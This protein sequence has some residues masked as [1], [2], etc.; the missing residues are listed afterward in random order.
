[1]KPPYTAWARHLR[2]WQACQRRSFR[3]LG[4]VA[5][6]IYDCLREEVRVLRLLSA[7][8]LLIFN[9]ISERLKMPHFSCAWAFGGQ[10]L[11]SVGEREACSQFRRKKRR[12]ERRRDGKSQRMIRGKLEEEGRKDKEWQRKEIPLRHCFEHPLKQGVLL[13][14]RHCRSEYHRPRRARYSSQHHKD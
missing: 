14:M 5:P 1:M 9:V 12:K 6:W 4:S 10:C 11:S 13:G 2:A 3:M 8:I 7:F